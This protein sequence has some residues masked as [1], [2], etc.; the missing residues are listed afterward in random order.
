MEPGGVQ[1]LHEERF[2]GKPW[3]QCDYINKWRF[4][5]SDTKQLDSWRMLTIQRETL[6][7]ALFFGSIAMSDSIFLW[8]YGRLFFLC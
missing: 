8:V 1:R 7:F 4:S 3:C 5:Y 2:C 6:G